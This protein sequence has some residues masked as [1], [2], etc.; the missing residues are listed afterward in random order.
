M[1]DLS[2]H[3]KVS[4]MLWF[5]FFLNPM[6]CLTYHNTDYI[7]YQSST[8]SF[9]A[10]STSVHLS[11]SHKK[12]MSLQ[13]SPYAT[14]PS[15]ITHKKLARQKIGC[16]L[17]PASCKMA[18]QRGSKSSFYQVLSLDNSESVGFDEIKKA[19]R[20]MAL[21]YPPDVC[22]SVAKEESTKRFVELQQAYETLSDPVSRKMYDY[23][24]GFD[25][26]LGP[27]CGEERRRRDCF[28]KK[29]WEE[30]FGNCNC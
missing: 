28:P 26:S 18:V 15:P 30:L 4:S 14:K 20:R 8:L 13:M 10:L 25:D 9:P 12:I 29:V 1:R 17:E 24:M 6:P 22:P 21:Q 7:I 27:L 19:Y 5:C 3:V 11:F 23:E 16:H 2:R